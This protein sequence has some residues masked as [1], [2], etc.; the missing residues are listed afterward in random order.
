[1]TYRNLTPSLRRI[2]TQLT[3][4]RMAKGW[5]QTAT[6]ARAGLHSDYISEIE[7]GVRRPSAETLSKLADLYGTQLTL[8]PHT[9]VFLDTTADIGTEL[10]RI[11]HTLGLTLE[12][13]GNAA[14]VAPTNL[15]SYERG[16][17]TPDPE[18]I[19]RIVAALGCRLAILGTR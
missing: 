7:R 6:A 11:R 14:H 10:R 17:R 16:T 8:E 5:T 3:A 19:I 18:T 15:S 13:V 12:D 9:P 4:L 2:I 1:M